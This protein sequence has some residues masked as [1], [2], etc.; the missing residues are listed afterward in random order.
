VFDGNKRIEKQCGL[1]YFTQHVGRVNV[2]A[3]VSYKSQTVTRCCF[4]SSLRLMRLCGVLDRL[5][6]NYWQ[7]NIPK[8]NKTSYGIT[9]AAMA[10]IFTALA[11]GI[12]IA[13]SI[14]FL[15]CAFHRGRHVK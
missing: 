8:I 2:A 3:P 1:K 7:S 12:L 9:F 15:E 4:F 13:T 10:P 11:F 6:R 5:R 14:L